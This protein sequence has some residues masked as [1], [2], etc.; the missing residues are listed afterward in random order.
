MKARGLAVASPR[1]KSRPT[2]LEDTPTSNPDPLASSEQ[3]GSRRLLS[4]K[5]IRKM[6]SL[7]TSARDAKS[8]SPVRGTPASPY[9]RGNGR[10]IAFSP[11]VIEADAAQTPSS[12]RSK[13][14]LALRRFKSTDDGVKQKTMSHEPNSGG[15][16]NVSIPTSR[17]NRLFRRPAAAAPATGHKITSPDLQ[18]YNSSQLSPERNNSYEADLDKVASGRHYHEDSLEFNA[19]SDDD[20]DLEGMDMRKME[21]RQKSRTMRFPFSHSESKTWKTF[22]FSKQASGDELSRFTSHDFERSGSLA[23]STQFEDGYELLD[24]VLGE[25]MFSEVVLGRRK[26]DDAFVAVK[27]VKKKGVLNRDASYTLKHETQF[28]KLGLDHTNVVSTYAVSNRSKTTLIVMEYIPGGTLKDAIDKYQPSG[29]LSDRVK[30]EIFR[31]MLSALAYLHEHLVAHRDVKPENILLDYGGSTTSGFEA[32]SPRRD[33]SDTV[34]V[35]KLAD[36]GLCKIFDSPNG[37][38]SGK[39]GSPLYV[40]P[41]V[42][43]YQEYGV[44]TDV[45]SLGVVM[46]LLFTGNELFTGDRS[47]EV[48]ESVKNQAIDLTAVSDPAARAVLAK[49][50]DRNPKTRISASQALDLPYFTM[51]L[52]ALAEESE[53][54]NLDERNDSREK[55]HVPASALGLL[56]PGYKPTNTSAGGV[57]AKENILSPRKQTASGT[58]SK[59]RDKSPS[60]ADSIRAALIG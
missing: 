5:G 9:A 26:I 13:V 55:Q 56:S 37:K 6:A 15:S 31:Q 17:R 11:E 33:L 18:S 52:N 47:E 19:A 29:G 25:G 32:P 42:V 20:D 30:R 57:T 10:S 58:N 16:N 21:S 59:S 49:M 22:G 27:V 12:T 54:T 48:M 46:Y 28:Y 8:V 34:P 35:A 39:V 2:G 43:N 3:L 7:D 45:W 40:A 24:T 44:E 1:H 14:T 50:I 36:F 51:E 23:G 60:A 41:E 53:C 38:V 4:P